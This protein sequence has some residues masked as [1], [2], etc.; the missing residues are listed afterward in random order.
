MS[1]EGGKYTRSSLMMGL[2]LL[3]FLL[4]ILVVDIRGNTLSFNYTLVISTFFIGFVIVVGLSF[5]NRSMAGGM[6]IGLSLSGSYW[7]GFLTGLLIKLQ[8]SS[9]T[10]ALRAYGPYAL[11]VSATFSALGLFFGFL[12][13]LTEHLFVENP[14]VETYVFRDY[15]S[16]VLSLG[17]S[18]RREFQDLDRRMTRAHVAAKDWWRQQIHRMRQA[19]PELI[20]VNQSTK[21]SEE[22]LGDIYDITS[23]QGIYHGVINPSDLI[24]LYKPTILSIPKTTNNIGGGRRLA[25]EEFISR[26]LGWFIQSKTLWVSYIALSALFTFSLLTYFNALVRSG[27]G[28]L[29]DTDLE[30]I[31]VTGVFLSAVTMIFVARFRARSLLLFEKRPDE[32][33][34]V[35][36][37]YIILF[38]F[39]G[40]IINSLRR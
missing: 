36:A 25:L 34:M 7:V 8:F 3:L 18:S 24:S 26:F 29:L 11:Y 10:D 12:G 31:I 16:S 1:E 33:A 30:A 23:G 4:G 5:L 17:K 9:N 28:Y 2:N 15:W 22:S 35:F 13:Y 20:Y 21:L 37:V 32:R 39:Y 14:N 40:L 19:K 38:M 6:V 27:G